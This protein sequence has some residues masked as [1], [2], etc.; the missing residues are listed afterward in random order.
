[1][2]KSIF[3]LFAMFSIVTTVYSQSSEEA[4]FKPHFKPVVKVFMDWH[5]GFGG[6]SEVDYTDH[7]GFELTRSVLGFQYQFSPR[8]SSKVIVDMDNPKAGKLTEVAYIRNAYVAYKDDRLNAV[9]GILGMKQF[10]TQENYWG[11]RYIYKSAMDEYKFNNSVDAGLYVKYQLVDWLSADMAITNGE[12]AKKQQ[13]T[14]G[15]YR[16]GYGLELEPID[17]L[18]FRT[19]YDYLYAPDATEEAMPENQDMISFFLGYEKDNVRLGVEYDILNNFKFEGSDDRD[20]FSAYGSLKFKDK[21][22]AFLRYDKLMAEN[23]MVSEN[24]SMAGFEWAVVK[25]V[26]IAPNFRYKTFPDTELPDAKY[27]YLNFEYKF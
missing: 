20:I 4:T 23:A 7:S 16:M 8:I 11:Y 25:G 24:V 5:Q 19:Y 14:E 22:Q 21:F 6:D 10:K 27:F 12:G 13:D 26:K 1:M 17:G 15:K 9:F 18:A 3:L 2:K